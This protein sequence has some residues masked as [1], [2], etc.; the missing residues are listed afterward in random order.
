VDVEVQP[1]DEPP[2]ETGPQWNSLS[3]RLR[4]PG[5]VTLPRSKWFARRTWPRH[6][7]VGRVGDL[8]LLI[9]D[10]N[11]AASGSVVLSDWTGR[12]DLAERSWLSRRQLLAVAPP[13][14]AAACAGAMRSSR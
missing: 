13:S 3:A 14:L 8:A 9:Y 2:F 1:A 7:T 12:G 10:L 6:A 11:D 4:V 5:V